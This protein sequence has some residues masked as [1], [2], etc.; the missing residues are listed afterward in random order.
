MPFLVLN[1]TDD[2]QEY[3]SNSEENVALVYSNNDYHCD[4]L[5]DSNCNSTVDD[6]GRLENYSQG[7]SGTRQ[8]F[9]VGSGDSAVEDLVEQEMFGIGRSQSVD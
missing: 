5:S 8:N 9:V 2:Y 4:L 7:K 6:F 1:S 3:P